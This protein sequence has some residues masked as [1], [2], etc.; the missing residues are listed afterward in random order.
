MLLICLSKNKIKNEKVLVEINGNL[1]G[2]VPEDSIEVDK[3]A[4]L[5]LHTDNDQALV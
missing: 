3:D 5:L 4:A 1:C 2:H